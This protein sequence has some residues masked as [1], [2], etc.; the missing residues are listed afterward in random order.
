[1]D[2]KTTSI[3]GAAAA[4]A[5]GPALAELLTPIPNAVERL[6]RAE[7]EPP[8]PPARLIEAQY[9]R[10]YDHHHHHHH[11][12]HHSRAWYLRNGYV[13]QGGGWILAPRPHHHHHHH[14]HHNQ[15]YGYGR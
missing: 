3:A 8:A 14:H 2:R 1:M 13:F 12:H 10:P 5:A 9:G 15:D 11:H 6:R 7:A 4:L